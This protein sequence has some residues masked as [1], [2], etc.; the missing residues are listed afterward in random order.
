MVYRIISSDSHA[1]APREVYLENVPAKFHEGIPHVA[2]GD[3]GKNYLWVRGQKVLTM[4]N[5]NAMMKHVRWRT[6]ASG[7]LQ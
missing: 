3:D 7:S 1:D 5:L 4:E 6:R 2:P